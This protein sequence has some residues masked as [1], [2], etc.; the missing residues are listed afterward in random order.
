MTTPETP[1]APRNT[2]EQLVRCAVCKREWPKG[3]EQTVAIRKRGKCIVCL[4]ELRE[5]FSMEPYEFPSD[6]DYA[7]NEA[8]TGAAQP[9]ACP[10][11][12]RS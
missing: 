5:P 7:P 12:G 8:V 6:P 4:I 11:G 3:C 9:I 2:E 10:A 1:A